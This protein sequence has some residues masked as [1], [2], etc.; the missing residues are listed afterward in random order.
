MS[1]PA[2]L[3]DRAVTSDASN[4]TIGPA[5]EIDERERWA[6]ATVLADGD[7][8][9]IRPITAADAPLL[10]EFH[11]GQPRDDLYLR[12]FSAKPS[13]TGKELAHF[14]VVD[15]H[16]RVALVMEHH[17][18]FIAWASYERWPGRADADVAFMVDHRHRGK[19]IA[20]LLLEHLAAIARFNGIERFTAEVLYENKAM[21]RV[22]ARAGWPVERHFDS[23]ISELTFPLGDTAEFIESVEQREH[24]ADSSA[25]TRLLLPR[26]IAVL[27]A[28]DL[29]G[30]AGE[31]LWRNVSTGF[32][33]QSYPV[34][35]RHATVGDRP[36]YA[37][38]TDIDDDVWLAVIAVP[39][40]QLDA[41]IDACIAKRVRGAVVVTATE[42]T[43]VDVEA[44]VRRARRNGMRIIGPASMGLASPRPRSRL[45][46]ALVD[47]SLPPGGVAISMQS[48]S[49]GA[50]LLRLAGEM[51]LGLSWFVSLGDKRDVSGNDLLQFWEDDERITV[52]AMYTESFGNPRKFA[53]IARRVSRRIPIV[54][55]RTGSAAVGAA[56]RALY[57]Q[58]GLIE[59]SGVR[60]L[61]DTARAFAT[62]PVPTGPN[63]AVIT[64][65]RSPGVLAGAAL[66]DAG[67]TVVPA[68]V[69]LDFT[70]QPVDFARAVHAALAD[71][72]V[73]SIMVIHAPA[74][75]GTVGPGA[76]LDGAARASA[77]ANGGPGPKPIVAVMLGHEDGPVVVGSAVPSFS[78]P[79]NAA[80][81]LGRMWSY[82]EW[83]IEERDIATDATLVVDDEAAHAAIDSAV[84]GGESTG[85][86]AAAWK[87]LG[88]YGLPLAR[89][90]FIAADVRRSAAPDDVVRA[91]VEVGFPVAVKAAH[92]HVGRSVRAGVA[93]D[94]TGGQAVL[95]ALAAMRT[96]LASD[97]DCVTVQE[98]VEPGVDVRIHCWNDD[99]VGPVVSVGLGSQQS[100]ADGADGGARLAPV[101]HA[102]AASLIAASPVGAALRSGGIDPRAIADAVV[103]L[104]RLAATHPRIVDLDVDP[105]IVSQHRVAITDATLTV[106]AT[107]ATVPAMRGLP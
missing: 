2:P 13:L 94:L 90:R 84:V 89:T 10:L 59:V 9:Y 100:E 81:V 64:N 60:Q 3:G 107:T 39:A 71:P 36:A 87:L 15:F 45:Q 46:A 6:V 18:E 74:L 14:T 51:S 24:R 83:L 40:E 73:H 19:G 98:M 70:A 62:Q 29:P 28:S 23:G 102:A 93:L 1:D 55:V 86:G 4:T 17:G 21:L 101:T 16:D 32:A 47:V 95:D 25:I 99:A 103:R 20:T 67:L 97:A 50:S 7:T 5:G 96:S 57:R 82:A 79:E 35:P 31:E 104:S 54:A 49:L 85:W 68:P 38:V 48:G 37:S 34:N 63:V 105:L 22:F 106:A 30:S 76:Q 11:E 26:S 65:S 91:A 72:G 80:A 44:L 43:D 78:F 92:R 42:G 56:T 53:R 75:A 66:A 61:L 33:G 41:A 58:T 8:A 88:A 52:I 12:F 27:G 69:Q 77:E